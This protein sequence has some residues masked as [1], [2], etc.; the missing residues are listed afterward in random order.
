MRVCQFRHIRI[1]QYSGDFIIIAY[2]A[3]FVKPFLQKNLRD[4]SADKVCRKITEF[5]VDMWQKFCP[6]GLDFLARIW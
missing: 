4:P 6:I 3:R 1:R 2:P 5:P